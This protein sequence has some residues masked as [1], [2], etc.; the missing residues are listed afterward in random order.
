[1]IAAIPAPRGEAAARILIVDDDE[2]NLLALSHVLE[3]V[4][5]VVCAASGRDALRELLREDFAVILLD[6]FM[7]DLDGYETAALIRKRAQSA[8]IPI[9]FLSAVNKETEHLMRGYAMGAVDYVFKPVDPV[10]LRSKVSVFVDLFEMRRQLEISERRQA[11]ILRA[12]P[13]AIYEVTEKDGKLLRRFHG[14]DLTHFLGEE[15]EAV[16]RSERAW[17]DWV[18]PEDRGLLFR[19]PEQGGDTV[20]VEYR[21]VGPGGLRHHILDQRIATTRVAGER[22]WAGSLLDITEQKEL[23]ARLVHAGKI[24]A[25]GQLTGGVAHDFNNLLAAILGGIGILERR[26]E[27]GEKEARVIDHM[28][29]AATQGTELVRRMMA[30]AR[31][32]ELTPSSVQPASLCESVAGLVTHTLGGNVTVAWDCPDLG[33]NLYVDRGQ[34]ELA[35]M[36]LIINARDAMPEGGEIGVSF[37]RVETP[38]SGKPMLRIRIA[39]S[40]CGIPADKLAKVTEPFFTTKETGKGTGLGLAM[41][42]GFVDQSGG[43]LHIDSAE[44][45]GTTI[46]LVLPATEER[47]PLGNGAVAG[48]LAW[49]A[50]KRLLLIDDDDAVREI[51]G[52]QFRDA[53]AAIDDFGSGPEALDAVRQAPDKYDL[54]L[55]DFAM[56]EMDGFETLRLIGEVA[57]R[58][59]AVLMSGNVDDLRLDKPL[60]VPLIRKPIDPAVLAGAFGRG[61]PGPRWDRP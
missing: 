17:E 10:V 46:D 15:A 51:L 36:N 55:C 44:G 4:A 47:S 28:R 41:V 52:E 24:D 60:G 43:E 6:V 29:H 58:A 7:P 22:R 21:W 11:S 56:P 18:H 9:I 23:E 38:A 33:L 1:V 45:R 30:F 59:R 61:G 12:L 8:R 26:L 32:Q 14:G 20:T 50:G 57:P 2:R 54:V 39:D 37:A 35:V 25:L 34:L 13:M 16:L 40:G 3:P 31:Q 49:L 27:L 42:S 48:D 5:S 19:E 53:G